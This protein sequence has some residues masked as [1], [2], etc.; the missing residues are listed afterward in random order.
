MQMLATMPEPV[1]SHDHD[2]AD[3]P[4]QMFA[5]RILIVRLGSMGDIIHTLPAI[6]TLRRRLPEAQI[7]WVVEDR[8]SELLSSP[9]AVSEV[10]RSSA[11]PLVDVL[12][13]A[14]TRE[15]RRSPFAQQTRNEVRSFLRALH[16]RRWEIAI[17]FQSAIRSAAIAQLSRAP[18]RIGFSRTIETPASLFYTRRF[19]GAGRHVVEQNIS[20][21]LAVARDAEPS[22]AFDL[23]HDAASE[24]WADQLLHEHRAGEFCLIS[25][26]AGWGAKRWP[27]ERYAEVARVLAAEGLLSVINFGPGEEPLAEAV[28]A[29]SEGCAIAAGCSISQLVALCRRA[30]LCL[31]GDTGPTHL[32]AALAVPVVAIYGPTD[33]ERNGP[34]GAPMIV[35]RSAMSVTDHARRGEPESGLLTITA[36][37]VIAA[38]LT[39]LANHRD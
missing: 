9:G 6:A 27:A 37:Q 15:W 3:I 14:H 4:Q 23:P 33:P 38:S 12:H 28:V 26:G 16:A 30:R 39:M 21:A 36:E 5:S 32:A 11:R 7:G 31:G 2:P 35:L 20:L 13:I 22:Y 29:Q 19:D 10:A 34:F 18:Q 8:W 1:L 25:P 17:D 24:I